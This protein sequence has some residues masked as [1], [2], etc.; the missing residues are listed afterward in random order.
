MIVKSFEK[1]KALSYYK[2]YCN[3]L[4]ELS[5]LN[6]NFNSYTNE[7]NSPEEYEILVEILN[8]IDIYSY[9]LVNFLNNK[10]VELTKTSILSL[11]EEEQ[12]LNESVIEFIKDLKEII[13]EEKESN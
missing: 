10:E 12:S 7:S 3:V 13:K 5:I 6:V 9:Y 2:K 1:N 11:T 4:N 8:K